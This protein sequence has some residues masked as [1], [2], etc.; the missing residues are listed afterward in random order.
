MPRTETDSLGSRE[1]PADA[2]YGIHTL[3]ACENFPLAGRSIRPA[4]IHAYGYVK[5]ACL[6]AAHEQT[7]WPQPT[8]EAL[9]AACREMQ[10]GELDPHIKVDALQGGAGTST[11]LNVCEVLTNRALVLLGHQ[12]GAC[13]ILDPLHDTNRYQSTNDTYPTALRLA[14]IWGVTQVADALTAL[15]QT[16]ESA[17]QQWGHIVKVGRTQLQDAV[18]TTVGRTFSAF[19]EAFARDRWRIYKCEERLRVINLGG[20]AI[21]S[22]IGAPRAYI[23]R[24]TELL[25]ARTGIGFA[26]AENLTEATQNADVFVEVSGML[27]ACATNL[28]KVC[29]DLRLLAS[30]PD[31]GI[32]ELQLPPRQAGSSIMPGKIN[33]VIP[34]AVTQAALR[35][36]TND[37]L[38]T[39]AA[40]MGNLELNAF[41]PVIADALLE[42]LALLARAAGI[43]DTHCIA[44]IH[45]N[46]AA[47]RQ[48]TA[49]S[50]ATATA[51]AGAIGYHAAAEL[52]QTA[53]TTG[54]SLRDLAQARHGL[55][56]DAF[57]TL[58]APETVTRLGSG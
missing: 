51:L 1:L 26:R 42:S 31:A 5:E 7:P 9:L 20:T 40:S 56:P 43:L 12:P 3:R 22:G 27:K 41:L 16:C 10:A 45:V 57:D 17:E 35:V 50:I 4:L 53:R 58:I 48:H 2:L 46:E 28:C 11:N 37:Q 49:Q 47:C 32:G 13:Q 36:Q 21:G 29:G 30:G 33:P 24:T 55:S 38:I 54:Q 19:A 14:A 39:T 34:E 23:F 18:L 44:G 25:R 8:W 52:L 15:Q 6:Q